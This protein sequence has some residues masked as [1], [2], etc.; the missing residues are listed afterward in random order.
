MTQTILAIPISDGVPSTISASNANPEQLQQ[1]LLYHMSNNTQQKNSGNRQQLNQNF[2]S[3]LPLQQNRYFQHQNTA[4]ETTNITCTPD[5][6]H[7]DS[8]NYCQY[9]YFIFTNYESKIIFLIFFFFFI[10]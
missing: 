3:L 6:I 4:D 10:R 8:D 1:Q 9:A 7:H 5:N 2:Q